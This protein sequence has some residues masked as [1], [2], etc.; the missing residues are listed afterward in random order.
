MKQNNAPPRFAYRCYHYAALLLDC[1]LS[2]SQTH[3]SWEQWYG[4]KP[5]IS[6]LRPFYADGMAFVSKEE[7]I[8]HMHGDS[9]ARGVP[10]KNLGPF[11]IEKH[12]L[13][14]DHTYLVFDVE[15][16]KM[17]PRAHCFFQFGVNGAQPFHVKPEWRSN[18]GYA[19]A[20]PDVPIEDFEYTEE[21]IAKLNRSS[22]APLPSTEI[23]DDTPLT[24]SLLPLHD[25]ISQELDISEQM[26]DDAAALSDFPVADRTRS[27]HFF[28]QAA[29]APSLLEFLFFKN[30]WEHKDGQ[31]SPLSDDAEAELFIV[32]D[33]LSPPSPD[34]PMEVD[35]LDQTPPEQ[36]PHTPFPFHGVGVHSLPGLSPFGRDQDLYDKDN[37]QLRQ[38][39]YARANPSHLPPSPPPPIFCPI[40]V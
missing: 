3:T 25:P 32:T 20:H 8:K 13:P 1:L 4:W 31:P 17:R 10:V 7:R 19:A 34:A 6:F 29:A 26:A 28:S 2:S 35:S 38:A 36:T 37:V 15:A 33:D 16:M 9:L 30:V 22:P 5:D 12:S 40:V 18:E 14:S 21:E 27:K 23:I 24:S 39:I 11:E